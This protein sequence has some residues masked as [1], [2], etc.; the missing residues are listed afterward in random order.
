MALEHYALE[1]RA[2]T[3]A[4]IRNH[5]KRTGHS[6]K[7]RREE[8]LGLIRGRIRRFIKK[9]LDCLTL[10]NARRKFEREFDG[11]DDDHELMVRRNARRE[12]SGMAEIDRSVSRVCEAVQEASVNRS[13]E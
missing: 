12:A 4:S 2:F 6:L 5:L 9:A 11:M 8:R 3:L 13:Y 10:H 1:R 7:F